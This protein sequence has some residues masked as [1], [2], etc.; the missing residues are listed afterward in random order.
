MVSGITQ[1]I[2]E[3]LVHETKGTCS[4]WGSSSRSSTRHV[5]GVN[6]MTLVH[7]TL[8]SLL[9]MM[10][11]KKKKKREDKEYLSLIL[12]TTMLLSKHYLV[13]LRLI[14][15]YFVV[16]TDLKVKA[17]AIAVSDNWGE[18]TTSAVHLNAAME[19]SLIRDSFQ[20]R[21]DI[22]WIRDCRAC[23]QWSLKA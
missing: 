21:V 23:S 20:N 11:Q 22:K 2:L 6:C 17:R 3:E 18:I 13:I 9:I 1:R 7:A 10:I 14:L 19:D 12:I 15:L 5:G 16:H 4:S 8:V